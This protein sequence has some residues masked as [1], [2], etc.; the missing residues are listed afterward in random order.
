MHQK[1]QIQSKSIKKIHK[2]AIP[3]VDF[4]CLSADP[5][6]FHLEYYRKPE[7]RILCGHDE[8][9]MQDENKCALCGVDYDDSFGQEWLQCP[10]CTRWFHESCV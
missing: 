6:P 3:S 4:Y 1:L 9:S 7:D 2:Y 10:S 5:E 8:S